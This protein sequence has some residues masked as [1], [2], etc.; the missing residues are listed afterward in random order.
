MLKIGGGDSSPQTERTTLCARDRT[1]STA[2][3][4]HSTHAPSVGE[5]A[6]AF[7]SQRTSRRAGRVRYLNTTTGQYFCYQSFGEPGRAT[8]KESQ[9]LDRLQKP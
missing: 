3:T 2:V 1:L 5:S 8:R 6:P 9:S 4:L 7:P